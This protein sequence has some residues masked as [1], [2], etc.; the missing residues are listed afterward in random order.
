MCTYPI[1]SATRTLIAPLF[2]LVL[3]IAMLT[4]YA[5]SQSFFT[6][7]FQLGVFATHPPSVFD[8]RVLSCII[9]VIVMLFSLRDCLGLLTCDNINSFI[10]QGSIRQAAIRAML[11]IAAEV[12]VYVLFEVCL[13]IFLDSVNNNTDAFVFSYIFST[14]IARFFAILLPIYIQNILY[15]VNKSL[16]ILLSGLVLAL[17]CINVDLLHNFVTPSATPA[18]PF[19]YLYHLN[20]ALDVSVYVLTLF[21][22][23]WCLSMYVLSYISLRFYRY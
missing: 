19:L 17:V 20:Y 5:R 18:V 22:F 1:R 11:Y 3:S 15:L 9:P 12:F 14:I 21:G 2:C 7:Y 23:M 13:C 16:S 10:R 6:F 4:F 8:V